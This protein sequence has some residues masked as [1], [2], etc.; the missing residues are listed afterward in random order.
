MPR[1][2]LTSAG[3]GRPK[4]SKNKLTKERIEEEIRRIAFLDPARLFFGTDE[5][6]RIRVKQRYSL[7]EIAD[8]PVEVRACIASIKVKTENLEAG[9]GT[10][11]ETVEIRLWPKV[12]ALELAARAFGMLRDKV[13]LNV[14]G[15]LAAQIAEGR[16]R[17]AA[18][19]KKG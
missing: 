12:Q 4:G 7:R 13:D 5:R 19:N 6:G 16:Q 14:T 9:D 11:D 2:R 18:R 17:A 8:M 3:P 1:H 15:D 10:Q